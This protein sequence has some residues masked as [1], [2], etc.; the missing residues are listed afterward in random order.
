VRRPPGALLLAVA[1]AVLPGCVVATSSRDSSGGGGFVLLLPLLVLALVFVAFRSSRRRRGDTQSRGFSRGFSRGGEEPERVN[2]QLLRA[3]LSVLADDVLRLEPR[4]ALKEEARDDFEA[5]TQRYRVAQA[6][7]EHSESPVDL[8]RLQRVVDEANWSMARVRAVLEG[9][10]PPAPPP[11]LQHPGPRGEPAVTVDDHDQPVNAGSPVSFRSGWFGVGGGL[12][13]G[14]LFGSML[15][16]FG[17]DDGSYD[18]AG[19][20][21]GDGGDFGF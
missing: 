9:R 20:G 3:E 15:D 6:A 2:E 1:L 14:L 12:F 17:G 16:D 8:M 5:A 21:G 4:V 7:I 19:D 10:P 13:T 11:T 18:G